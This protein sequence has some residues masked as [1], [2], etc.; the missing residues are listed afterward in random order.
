MMTEERFA[1]RQKDARET[2]ARLAEAVA[3][4]ES[5]IVGD[6]VI[7]RFTFEAVWKALKL[8]LEGFGNGASALQ[9]NGNLVVWDASAF[10]LWVRGSG[11]GS[12][13]QAG[14]TI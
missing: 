6:A 4:P 2:A 3:M 12:A 13:T 9:M 10:K 5:E 8:S 1:E 7:Q 14:W 11:R